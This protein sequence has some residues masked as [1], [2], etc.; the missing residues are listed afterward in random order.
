MAYG[1]K[2]SSC[3]PLI[4]STVYHIVNKGIFKSWIC[5]FYFA[6]QIVFFLS[7]WGCFGIRIIFQLLKSFFLLNKK[8]EF[9]K[10]NPL[11]NVGNW[12]RIYG[13]LRWNTC[14]D[15]LEWLKHCLDKIWFSFFF[16]FFFFFF[17]FILGLF[18]LIFILGLW[19]QKV[20]LKLT[21]VEVR[22]L[23]DHWNVE[24]YFALLYLVYFFLLINKYK[25]NLFF[26][27]VGKHLIRFFFSFLS[28]QQTFHTKDDEFSTSVRRVVLS[29]SASA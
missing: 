20:V 8:A 9:G 1:L 13:M 23:L 10:K 4:H 22:Y 3:N 26:S 18:F 14:L 29:D 7:E 15:E 27:Y 12:N 5:M 11:Q 28:F 24:H 25:T 16:F 2:A 17:N 21:I 6:Y 19:F